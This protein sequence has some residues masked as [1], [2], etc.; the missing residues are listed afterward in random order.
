MDLVGRPR[1]S[2]VPPVTEIGGAIDDGNIATD[3]SIIKMTPASPVATKAY[4]TSTSISSD[5]VTRPTT[6][7]SPQNIR[8]TRNLIL[9]SRRSTS[10]AF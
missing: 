4:T 7:I 6:S 5:R 8:C 9:Q 2:N 1:G 10:A 3:V